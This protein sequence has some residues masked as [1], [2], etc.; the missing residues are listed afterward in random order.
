M[1]PCGAPAARLCMRPLTP[2]CPTSPSPANLSQILSETKDPTR[3]QPHLR[4]C[5]EGIHRLE[6]AP[7]GTGVVGAM[8]SME[9]GRGGG[10]GPAGNLHREGGREGSS[11][12]E[13]SRG[14][15]GMRGKRTRKWHVC[16]LQRQAAERGMT[17]TELFP[18]SK[19]PIVDPPVADSLGAAPN[20]QPDRFSTFPGQFLDSL[21]PCT[22]SLRFTPTPC[23]HPLPPGRAR[24]LHAARQHGG[25]ARQGG[26]VAGGGEGGGGAGPAAE[27][28]RAYTHLQLSAFLPPEFLIAIYFSAPKITHHVHARGVSL[29]SA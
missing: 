16:H 23:T 20:N 29:P 14:K 13:W 19:A 10:S 9:V 25:G 8:V 22:V 28:P 17:C 12:A 5:F 26:A 6:F 24:A 3:V 2:S 7:G 27:L 21:T 4:K 15:F 1:T 11:V 18:W